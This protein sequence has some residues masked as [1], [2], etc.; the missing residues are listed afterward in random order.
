MKNA[1]QVNTRKWSWVSAIVMV[2]ILAFVAGC[3]ESN[4]GPIP[5]IEAPDVAAADT[6]DTYGSAV[7][8]S[9]DDDDE[10]CCH[11]I[12]EDADMVVATVNG[13]EITAG[14]VMAELSWAAD[15]LVAE[16]IGLFPDDTEFDFDRI[17]RDDLTFGRVL[18]E[19]AAR[20][21]AHMKLFYDFANHH[22]IPWDMEG[23]QHPVVEVVYTIIDNAELFVQFES[24]MQ[25]DTSD[26]Y[27]EKAEELLARALAGE[28]FSSLIE[29]YGEDP[30]MISFP[31][32]YTFFA[33][34][35]VTPFEE[36]TLELEIGEISGLVITDF[37]IHIIMRV[38]PDPENL[39]P[40]SQAPADVAVEDLLGAKHIL[41][42]TSSMSQE[43]R[44]L[45]AVLMAFDAKLEVADIEFLLGLDEV[46][47]GW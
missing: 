47:L 37:G 26:N 3:Y 13:M 2:F 8:A 12:F 34:D 30:G 24:Y 5:H 9:I 25:E 11:S 41:I 20:I 38:E 33:G 32:G 1:K 10:D 36:A 15:S 4:E 44:M 28:D 43:D 42:M 31:D 29:T 16:Y 18:R 23:F 22:D 6:T 14:E 46:P 40:G 19:E 7:G 27:E 21:A 35:M 17:F 45:E 39:L